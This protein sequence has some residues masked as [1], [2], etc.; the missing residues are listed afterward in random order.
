MFDGTCV[1]KVRLNSMASRKFIVWNSTGL[2][3]SKSTMLT[4]WI[5]T[6]KIDLIVLIEGGDAAAVQIP[7]DTNITKL[8]SIHESCQVTAN[9]TVRDS[10][11][12]IQAVLAADKR[13]LKPVGGKST[14][15]YYAITPGLKLID[16]NALVKYEESNHDGSMGDHPPII[17]RASW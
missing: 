10:E 15:L 17:F 4:A 7:P 14:L 16:D 2:D 6:Y 8:M 11:V 1:R 3:K 12:K 13:I 5:S 9:L